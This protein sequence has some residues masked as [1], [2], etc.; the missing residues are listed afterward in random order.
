[1]NNVDEL[2]IF[3]VSDSTYLP[4]TRVLF[5]SIKCNVKTPYKFHLH[6]VNVPDKKINFFKDTYENIEVTVDKIELD[7]KPDFNNSFNKSK[8]AAYCANI[9]AK[10]I[11]DLM[12]RGCKYILYLDADSIVRKDLNQLLEMIKNTDIIIA[13]R[14]ESPKIRSKVLTGVIG[15]N[16]N[17]NSLKFVDLW[18]SLVL[19]ELSLYRWYTDQVMFTKAME[20]NIINITDL[21][22]EYIDTARFVG[23]SFI[24]CGKGDRKF[25]NTKYIQEMEKYK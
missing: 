23:G 20:E 4:F 13:T 21:P 10:G 6:T 15:I 3:S 17:L 7:E 25:G 12:M 14:K 11:H 2:V 9:R 18:K 5:N 1:M 16:N 19:N 24:W 8:K 22:L